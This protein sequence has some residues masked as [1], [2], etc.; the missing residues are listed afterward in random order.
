MLSLVSQSGDQLLY[1]KEIWLD[2]VVDV[3]DDP[4]EKN[5]RQISYRN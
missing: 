3:E 5:E 1:F 4:T 2:W